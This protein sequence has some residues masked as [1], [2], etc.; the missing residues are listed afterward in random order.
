[1]RT[2]EESLCAECFRTLVTGIFQRLGCLVRR[3]RGC[4][5]EVWERGSALLATSGDFGCHT[6]PGMSFCPVGEAG[7]LGSTLNHAGQALH[8]VRNGLL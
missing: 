8:H 1:V 4:R 7:M 2:G 6:E 5:P 3:P